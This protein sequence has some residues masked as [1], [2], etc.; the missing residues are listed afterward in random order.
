MAAH[1]GQAQRARVADQLAQHAPAGRQRA[2]GAALLLVD[3]ARHEPGQAVTRLV[4][5][6]QRRVARAGEL[7]GRLQHAFEH[8]LEIKLLEHAAGDLEDFASGVIQGR[9]SRSSR[10][11]SRA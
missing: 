10:P 1:I 3:P 9:Q 6:A 2:D 4:Q 11:C 7:A 5:H 8:Q